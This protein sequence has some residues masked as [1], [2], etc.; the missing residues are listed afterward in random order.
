M[1]YQVLARK[2][3]PHNFKQVVGQQ[4]VLTALINALQQ[5]RLHHAYLFSGTRGV[6]KTSIARILAKS[7]NCETGV[8]AEPCGQCDHCQAIEQGRFVDLLEIDA[9]SRTKVEDTREL[10]DNVQYKPAQGRYKVYLIDEVH[11]LSKHS[12]NALLKTLEEPPE[13]V[14]FL[15]ATTDPQKLPITILSRC[16]QFH[17]KSLTKSDISEQ[18][19]HI[20]QQEQHGF[21][22]PA[23][24][25]LAK[26]ANGSMRD[27]LSLTDQAIAFG[28]GSVQYDSVLS[29][30]GTLDHKQ[31]YELLR[32]ISQGDVNLVFDQVAQL[33]SLGPDF[34][35]VLNELANALHQVALAQMLPSTASGNDDH[36]AITE[37]ARTF[38]AE[39]VQLCYQ[40]ALKGRQDLPL[41]P[42]PRVGLEMT[43]MRMLAFRPAPLVDIEPTMMAPANQS[44][45]TAELRSHAQGTSQRQAST[46]IAKALPAPEAIAKTCGQ[47]VSVMPVT[48]EQESSPANS[49]GPAPEPRVRPPKA[50]NQ[51]TASHHAPALDS[52]DHSMREDKQAAESAPLNESVERDTQQNAAVNTA[53]T[54]G[55]EQAKQTQNDDKPEVSTAASEP[56]LGALAKRN[57]LRSR[58][59]AL[60]SGEKKTAITSP[61]EA[62]AAA[63]T[64]SKE[65]NRMATAQDAAISQPASVKQPASVATPSHERSI[66]QATPPYSRQPGSGETRDKA[67]ISS[68]PQADPPSSSST[69]H[70]QISPAMDPELPPL[71]AYSQDY[72]AYFQADNM[73]A[74]MPDEAFSDAVS[75]AYDHNS[76]SQQQDYGQTHLPKTAEPAVETELNAGQIGDSDNGQQSRHLIHNPSSDSSGNPSSHDTAMLPV[77]N[78]F[79][80]S[81]QDPWCQQINQ[82]GLSGILRQLGLNSV[83]QTL[84]PQ[85]ALVLQPAHQHLNNEK[86]QQALLS[87][88]QQV[89]GDNASVA[90]TIGQVP[91]QQTPVEI[92][93]AIYLARLNQAKQ[94]IAEDAAIQFFIQRFAAVVDEDS[95][96]PI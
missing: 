43:L 52:A 22:P 8:T 95:I 36:E 56:V 13:Y 94:D 41:A 79:S 14:K 24:A 73:P 1:S 19:S 82:L 93:Q 37:L 68:A 58:K 21:E 75:M 78:T 38:S 31:V 10:L 18:L 48:P 3:R 59:K 92:E 6:G 90:I 85:L 55:P 63:L 61:K 57:M 20:L 66:A 64:A 7:L 2:W 49:P 45:P 67:P 29:M 83:A 4:H 44:A 65:T 71:D 28:N 77:P 88:C 26:A 5:Q 40:I 81:N 50:D 33:V 62:P 17:L 15:L 72:Q 46:P 96:K 39:Q 80:Q 42:E 34:D 53:E 89:Y 54:A 47:N 16:L 25:L 70:H 23:L 74:Q 91:E 27:A 30:L 84:A 76:S 87:A 12:F 69:G 86:N 11:M 60:Q 32:S 51:E 9:A 35:Q